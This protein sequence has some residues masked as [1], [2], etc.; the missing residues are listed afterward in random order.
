MQDASTLTS[1]PDYEDICQALR[2]SRDP[3]DVDKSSTG[4]SES[5]QDLSADSEEDCPI[6]KRELENQMRQGPLPPLHEENSSDSSANQ[7]G[8]PP[9]CST[10]ESPAEDANTEESDDFSLNQ[11]GSDVCAE[12]KNQHTLTQENVGEDEKTDNAQAETLDN[13]CAGNLAESIPAHEATDESSSTVS[14]NVVTADLQVTEEQRVGEK[15]T[16]DVDVGEMAAIIGETPESSADKQSA[17]VQTECEKLDSSM[18]DDKQE[19][20]KKPFAV[21]E[22]KIGSRDSVGTRPPRVTRVSTR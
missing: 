19:Q 2:Q 6:C 14:A 1:P 17:E 16:K 13:L 10:L 8:S 15:V 22:H 9:Q 20:K 11:S 5:L 12:T 3:A 7:N 21:P 4:N 18:P